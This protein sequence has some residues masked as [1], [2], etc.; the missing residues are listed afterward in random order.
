MR[1][2]R[3]KSC[4]LIAYAVVL[5]MI[6]FTLASLSGCMQ[7]DQYQLTTVESESPALW[8][9][10]DGPTVR[11]EF[12]RPGWIT[13]PGHVRHWVSI[14]ETNC[15]FVMEAG[16]HIITFETEDGDYLTC[17]VVVEGE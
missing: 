17:A 3:L 8:C 11:I 14:F 12:N 10:V 7:Q 15:E 9:Y 1:G 2:L 16:R 5:F 13:A 6:L 4:Y